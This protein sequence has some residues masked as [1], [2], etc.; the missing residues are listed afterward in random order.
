MARPLRLHA[1]GMLHHLMSRGND[2]RE[3]FIDDVDYARYL[4]LLERSSRRFGIEVIAYCLMPNH[5]HLLLKPA[6]HPLSRLMQHVNS[7]YCGW[8]NRRHGRVGH[9]LQGR[10]KAQILESGPSFLRVLRYIMLN[11][12]NARMVA[13]PE[14]WSWSSFG[15]SVGAADL[16]SL[17]SLTDVWNTFDSQDRQSAQRSFRAFVEMPSP[18]ETEEGLLLG[19]TAFV[20]RFAPILATYRHDREL[21]HAERFAAR[22]SLSEL[23]PEMTR[24]PGIRSAA[25]AAFHT[26]AFTLREIGHHVGASPSA[27]WLWTQRVARVA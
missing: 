20:R 3:M 11:P 21:V 27:V 5:V 4:E 23:I 8:F 25:H 13:R 17:L 2:K 16:P 26:H 9:V 10:Y 24:G 15:A 22:P 14:D 1:P 6:L 7:A 19:S 18:P 12:V